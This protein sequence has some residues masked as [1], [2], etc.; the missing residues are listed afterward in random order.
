MVLPLGPDDVELIFRDPVLDGGGAQTYDGNGRPVYTDRV[1]AKSGAKFTIISVSETGNVGSNRG[2]LPPVAVYSAKCA[3]G[4]DADALALRK[5]DA[6]RHDGKVF[7]LSGDAL[8]KLTLI[9]KTPHHVRAVCSREELAARVERVVVTPRGGQDDY[10][11]RLPD[12]VPFTVEAL[13]IDAGNTAER[14]G[15]RGTTEEVDFTVVLPLG[16]GVRDGDWLA[17]RGREGGVARVQREFSQH[18]E[19]NQDVVLVRFVSG[20]G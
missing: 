10:G 8:L 13:A 15:A 18:A 16:V 12:G 5:K 2:L 14:Y 1:V 6:I 7:E 9:D 19:R 3:L 20:G 17:F 11:R 4:V